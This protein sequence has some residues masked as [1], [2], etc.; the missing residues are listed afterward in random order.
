MAAEIRGAFLEYFRGRGHEVIPSGPLV[1]SSDPTLMFTAAGMVPFKDVFT[2]KE[3][4]AYTRATSSQKCIRISG[5]H[6]DLENVGVTARHHTFFEM[7]GN[8]SFGDYFK[9]EAIGAAWSFLT[10]TLGVDRDKLVVTVFGGEDGLP[11]DDEAAAL[12]R[13]VAGVPAERILRCGAEDNYWSM[14]DT[15][16]CG[17]CAEI[18]YFVGEGSADVADFGKEPSPDGTGWTEIWNLVFMQFDRQ[19][20][21]ALKELPAPSIDTGMGLERLAVVLQGVTSNYD[22][23]LLRPLVDMAASMSGRAYGGTLADDD[24]SMRVIADHARTAAFLIAEGVFPDRDGRAYVLRRVMRRA[25]RHG[26]R[27]GLD[28]LFLHECAL[29]VVDLMGVAYPELR[30]RRALVEDI[31]KQEE[32]RFRATLKRGLELIDHQ[33]TWLERDGLRH[34]PGAVA[35]RLYDTFGFPVDLQGVIGKERG[36]VVDQQGFDAALTAARE[37]SGAFKNNE[38]ATAAVYHQLKDRHGATRFDGYERERGSGEVLAVLV[39]GAVVGAARLGD[40]AELVVDATPFYAESGGQTG[41]RGVIRTAGGVFEVRDTQKP[42]DGLFVHRGVVRTGEVRSGQAELEVDHET[43]A[44]ARRNHSATHLLHYALR[45]VLGPQAM[46]KGSLV[47]SDRLRFDYSAAVATSPEQ[48]QR[49]EDL[50]NGKILQNA[51]ITVDVMP[52]PEARKK[53]AVGI[54]EEKYGEVVRVLTM[55][56]DSVEL[57]GGTHAARTGD[58]GLFKI[59]SDAGLA[60]G[61]RRME[62]ATGLRAL[63]YVRDL[64]E[65]LDRTATLVKTQG[66]APSERVE[67]LVHRERDLVKEVARLQQKLAS[68]GG[69]QGLVG[70]AQDVDGVKVLGAVVDLGDAKALRDMADGLRDRLQPAAVLLGT[71][72]GDKAVLVCSVSKGATERFHAGNIVREAAKRVGGKG[73]GRPDFAQA[74]GHDVSQLEAAVNHDNWVTL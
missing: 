71:R 53:G 19:A 31:T 64:E 63:A 35:F 46:Q 43:R 62:A 36:F 68:G 20:D 1:P 21:G 16:P 34:L 55:T 67:R 60:A 14:G 48:L 73:G 40:E 39:D 23:D 44:A 57:C 26:H 3:S 11:A 41:D 65:E 22:T 29:R 13:R 74:G 47:S 28:R 30:E 10:E 50:V 58:I 42:V 27:L 59:I 33:D 51:P 18:H 6:N 54:F 24:V 45:T 12:W 38:V 56:E 61:V 66:R 2:G 4:R 72:V 5:K 32:T 8:F 37:K 17:P 25:I 7:L 9:E 15:G 70:Q 69:A 52:M 49:V